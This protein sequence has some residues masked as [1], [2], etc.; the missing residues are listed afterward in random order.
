MNR[1]NQPELNIFIF[2]VMSFFFRLPFYI[3]YILFQRVNEGIKEE[4]L[5]RVYKAIL[6]N[7]EL[8]T[9]QHG[10]GISYIILYVLCENILYLRLIINT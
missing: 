10:I 6:N 4:Y 5:Q 3:L 8:D 7:A 1:H 2:A 9:I